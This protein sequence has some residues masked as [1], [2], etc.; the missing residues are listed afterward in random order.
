MIAEVEAGSFFTLALTLDRKCLYA[1]GDA[2]YGQCGISA[3]VPAPNTMVLK[4]QQVAF[5]A[6]GLE[7]DQI[8][9]GENHSLVVAKPKGGTREVYTV[10]AKYNYVLF[11]RVTNKK[12]IHPIIFPCLSSLIV[13]QHCRNGGC[14]YP[15][16]RR[17]GQERIPPSETHLTKE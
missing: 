6:E 8:S 15:G 9:C 11:M 3:E 1:C 4:L 14:L 12:P 7:F 16:S 5:P 17:G 2:E 13:G 10:G